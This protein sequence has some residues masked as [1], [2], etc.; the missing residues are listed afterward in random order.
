M[1]SPRTCWEC[2]YRVG[3]RRAPFREHVGN[4]LRPKEKPSPKFP[5]CRELQKRLDLVPRTGF[6]KGVE[7]RTLYRERNS[8]GELGADNYA[9]VAVSALFCNNLFNKI[10]DSWSHPETG[11]I[12]VRTNIALMSAWFTL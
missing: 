12:R 3:F 1:F 10:L 11:V 6:D 2:T 7:F 5:A 8:N 9:R 4:D